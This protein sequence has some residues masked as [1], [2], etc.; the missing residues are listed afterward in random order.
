MREAQDI[1]NDQSETA[2]GEPVAEAAAGSASPQL[3]PGFQFIEIVGEGGAS[4]VSKAFEPRLQQTVAIKILKDCDSPETDLSRKLMRESR[5]IAKLDHPNIVKLFQ[6]GYTASGAPYLVYEYLSGLT[7]EQAMES[8]SLHPQEYFVIFDEILKGLAHIHNA[9]LVHRDIK[10][11]NVILTHGATVTGAFSGVKILD[12]GIAKEVYEG[13]DPTATTSSGSIVGSPPYMSPEQCQRKKLDARSDLYSVACMLYEALSKRRVF[14]GNTPM[15]IM[16]KQIHEPVP[17]LPDLGGG[18]SF[19]STFSAFLLKALSKDPSDRPA[20]AN[21][22]RVL[23]EQSAALHKDVLPPRIVVPK[24]KLS[25]SLCVV[26]AFLSALLLLGYGVFRTQ[27]AQFVTK[28]DS[29]KKTSVRALSISSQ[30]K[31]IAYDI[32]T[33]EN[34]GVKTK[35]EAEIFFKRLAELGP[36]VKTVADRYAVHCMRAKLFLWKG[37]LEKYIQEYKLALPLCRMPAGRMCIEAADCNHEIG[38]ALVSLNRKSEAKQYFLKAKAL[39]DARD[40]DYDSVGSL[41]LPGDYHVRLGPDFEHRNLEALGGIYYDAGDYSNARASYAAIFDRFDRFNRVDDYLPARLRLAEIIEKQDGEKA[42]QAF[43][44]GYEERLVQYRYV[45][46]D[47]VRN[48]DQLMDYAR[49]KHWDGMV[50]KLESDKKYFLQRVQYR[51]DRIKEQA[52]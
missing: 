45:S 41:N 47:S 19:Q 50:K 42:A 29:W 5:A 1:K 44:L 28:K 21:E 40:E 17:Q 12:F 37:E 25:R 49:K 7:L 33:A 10:P 2:A 22:F 26:G 3:P 46:D 30:I 11:S 23:L 24:P 38:H 20:N 15:D 13:D 51:K 35:E 27:Q 48:F 36:Q 52:K 16:Y 43:L 8:G 31:A 14:S 32:K 9:G 34:L 6:V 39:L 4:V 18:A